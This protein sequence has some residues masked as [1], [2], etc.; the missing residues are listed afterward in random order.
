MDDAGLLNDFTCPK[1][2]HL[3]ILLL[4]FMTQTNVNSVFIP[5]SKDH[6]I[7]RVFCILIGIFPKVRT[8]F[9]AKFLW[10]AKSDW[11]LWFS[12]WIRFS[13]AGKHLNETFHVSDVCYSIMS[14]WSLPDAIN[15]NGFVFSTQQFIICVLST[16]P[17][18]L[19]LL[20]GNRWKK[21]TIT[22]I[23]RGSNRY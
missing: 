22:R 21:M 10:M 3:L 8:S 5:K 6:M 23:S 11:F 4:H 2:A 20:I 9:R 19:W 18:R 17:A 14:F 1:W 15:L 16:L 13:I 12:H 7:S